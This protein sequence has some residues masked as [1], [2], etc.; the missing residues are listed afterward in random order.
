MQKGLAT[1]PARRDPDGRGPLGPLE[2]GPP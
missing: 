2:R 1:A